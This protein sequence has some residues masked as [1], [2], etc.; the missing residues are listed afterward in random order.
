MGAHACN[1]YFEFGTLIKKFILHLYSKALLSQMMVILS[2]KWTI[3]FLILGSLAITTGSTLPTTNCSI[4][5]AA[6][7]LNQMDLMYGAGHGIHSI[8]VRDIRYYFDPDFPEENDIPTIN[9]D[10]R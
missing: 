2:T 9:P 5:L 6:T 4:V 8:T 3:T 1:A 10:F 7:G